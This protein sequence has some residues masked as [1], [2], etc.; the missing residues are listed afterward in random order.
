MS[1]LVSRR[2]LLRTS[3]LVA[4][5]LVLGLA[6]QQPAHAAAAPSLDAFMAM[7]QA[8]AGRPSLDR[9]MGQAILNAFVT[10]GQAGELSALVA[11]ADPV[12]SQLK[13][14]DAVLA[15]WYSGLSPAAGAADVTGF[16]EALVWDALTYTKPWGSCGGETGYWS[17]IPS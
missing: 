9:D 13:I 4:S 10:S 2:A 16:N 6:A 8:L 3:G 15:A 12:Q 5:A 1:Y 14:A 17:E 7:S 11:E